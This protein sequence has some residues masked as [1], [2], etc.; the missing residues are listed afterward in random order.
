[1]N[2]NND[3]NLNKYKWLKW[4]NRIFLI[5]STVMP[6]FYT[7]L[8]FV[9]IKIVDPSPWGDWEVLEW[10]IFIAPIMALTWFMPLLGAILILV[11]TN[12]VLLNYLI[13]AAFGGL[14]MA[15]YFIIP[16][17]F[18]LIIAGILSLSWGIVRRRER[19]KH[20]NNNSELKERYMK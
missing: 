7:W 17:Y 20:R 19:K 1:M 11:G 10:T 18:I 2:N 8:Y 5:L 14:G 16:Q 4:T 3:T 13:G 9:F 15:S 12:L 6:A